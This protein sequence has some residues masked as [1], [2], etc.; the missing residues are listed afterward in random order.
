MRKILLIIV[1]IVMLGACVKDIEHIDSSTM[2]DILY[3]YHRSQSSL[4]NFEGDYAYKANLYYQAVLKKYGVTQ[5][6][7]DSSMVYYLRHSDDLQKIYER[8]DQRLQEDALNLGANVSEFNNY[9]DYKEGGDTANIWKG[10]RFY[11]LTTYVPYNKINFSLKV[12]TAYH[13][14]DKLFWELNSKF[15]YQDGFK[16]AIMV[17]VARYDNDSIVTLTNTFSNDGHQRMNMVTLDDH[18]LTSL[19]GFLM[20]NKGTGQSK[21]TL[22]LLFL[23]D[24]RLIRCHVKKVADEDAEKTDST[25]ADKPQIEDSTQAKPMLEPEN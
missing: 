17:L 24:V 23:N 21:T 12:D 9:N 4:D 20:I 11:A 22:K 7:F 10:Q 13:P 19:K 5:A 6:E 16:N 25:E 1:A 18:K 3:D 2:E 8:L 15:H 14:G